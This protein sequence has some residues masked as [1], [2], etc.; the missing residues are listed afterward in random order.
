MSSSKRARRAPHRRLPLIALNCDG[1]LT[2]QYAIDENQELSQLLASAVAFREQKDSESAED[3][4]TTVLESWMEVDWV[5]LNQASVTTAP[6][7]AHLGCILPME[8]ASLDTGLAIAPTLPPKGNYGV[9]CLC[10][11]R[12]D[13]KDLD[14]V[15][16]LN[17][18][19]VYPPQT[20]DDV[21]RDAHTAIFTPNDMDVPRPTA[22]HGVFLYERGIGVVFPRGI[23]IVEW[24]VAFVYLRR[25]GEPMQYSF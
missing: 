20:S 18:V 19:I 24:R 3:A 12:F 15:Y 1:D 17:C 14:V 2:W 13:G 4:F 11:H 9:L 25:K 16:D 5:D 21:L 23:C 10:E 6:T 8:N 22:S 7:P